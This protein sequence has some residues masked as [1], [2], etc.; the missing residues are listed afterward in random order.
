MYRNS[1]GY[2]V[3][4][5]T[6]SNN[7]IL[8][9]G[10]QKWLRGVRFSRSFNQKIGKRISNIEMMILAINLNHCHASVKQVFTRIV[11]SI[12]EIFLPI[13]GKM[14]GW[15]AMYNNIMSAYLYSIQSF[16]PQWFSWICYYFHYISTC[17]H[18]HWSHVKICFHRTILHF[19]NCF[20]YIGPARKSV[21][22]V[23]ITPRGFQ[24]SS[25]KKIKL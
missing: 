6:W 17:Y 18:K 22:N 11:I 25:P 24:S 21:Y 9:L 7:P 8:K 16:P 14:S 20:Y 4:F 15:T 10:T 3:Y 2:L 12:L 19:L 13:F 23:I 1:Y 5:P